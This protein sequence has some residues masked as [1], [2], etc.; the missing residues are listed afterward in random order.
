AVQVTR[1]RDARMRQADGAF[2]RRH[3]LDLLYRVEYQILQRDAVVGDA[4]DEAGVGTVFQQTT[5]QIGQQ[6][7][8]AAHRCVDAARAVQLAVFDGAYYLLVQRLAHA[9]QALELVLARVVVLPGQVIDG[10]QRMGVVRGELRV[11]GFR[12]GQQLARTG[13]VGDIGVRLAGVHRV[14][15]QAVDLGQLDLA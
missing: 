5:H 4:V 14:A 7:L 1:Q 11:D 3:L 2:L 10:R 12:R 9:V 13:D 8:V 15:F 6:G